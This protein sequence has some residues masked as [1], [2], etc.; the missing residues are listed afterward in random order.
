MS[1]SSPFQYER[2]VFVT[3][4]SRAGTGTL[5]QLLSVVA[6]IRMAPETHYFA[7]LRKQSRRPCAVQSA[8]SHAR[9]SE[10]FAVIAQSGYRHSGISEHH[11]FDRDNHAALVSALGS[12]LDSHFVAFC[13]GASPTVSRW[14]EKTPRHAYHH[15]EMLKVFPAAQIIH[16]VRDPRAVLASYK[17]WLDRPAPPDASEGQ[18]AD[19]IR[20]KQSYCPF[21]VAVLWRSATRAAERSVAKFGAGRVRIERYEDLCDQ[22]EEVAKRILAWLGESCIG[23]LSQLDHAHSSHGNELTGVGVTSQSRDKWQDVL[24]KRELSEIEAVCGTVMR[25]WGYEKVTTAS[26]INVPIDF[27][28]A[29]PSLFS[30]AI[31]NQSRM[32]SVFGFV[33]SRLRL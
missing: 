9:A 10:Y 8:E 7:D 2:P 19:R 5:R 33:S 15:A 27:T 14:G 24:S 23:S 18:L 12:S 25:R 13:R 3:G 17:N 28:L 21:A 16:M 32:G 30:A 20:K 26:R 31:A 1:T 4:T 6:G 11:S 22:A 29:F